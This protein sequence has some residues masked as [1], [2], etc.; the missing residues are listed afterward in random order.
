M[1]FSPRG[2]LRI[3]CL[4]T[5]CATLVTPIAG[6]PATQSAKPDPPPLFDFNDRVKAYVTLR[7]KVDGGAPPLRETKD[8]AKIQA[9]QKALAALI[10][11]ARAT[12]KQGDIFSP[13]IEK[14]FRS[15]LKGEATADGAKPK[16]ASPEENPQ[17]E[18]K[19]N[20]EYPSDEPHTSVS[21]TV[22][23][24]LPVLP[25]GEDLEY[26]FV[27]KHLILVDTRANLIVDFV[28]NALS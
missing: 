20:S 6:A 4:L 10:R 16:S 8:P 18:L 23:E 2:C 21:P 3:V 13:A 28:F 26:R 19:V 7:A 25:K 11:N 24:A 5:A 9:A 17:V 1:E 12:A 27:R 22:L 14:A 15:L